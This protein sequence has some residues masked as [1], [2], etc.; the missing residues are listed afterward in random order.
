MTTLAQKK[1][2]E[3]EAAKLKAVEEAVRRKSAEEAQQRTLEQMR[4]MAS[5]YSAEDTTAT[6]RV[7]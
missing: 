1:A 7:V 3:A 5:K 6:I 4:Q 2:R